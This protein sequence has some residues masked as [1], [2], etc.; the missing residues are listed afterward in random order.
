MVVMMCRD[1]NVVSKEGLLQLRAVKRADKGVY[2]CNAVNSLGV[3]VTQHLSLD[4]T[5]ECSARQTD[6]VDVCRM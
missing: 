2:Q 3:N 5:C 6:R 4:V 1:G